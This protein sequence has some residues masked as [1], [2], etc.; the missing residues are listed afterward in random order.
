MSTII[1][2]N[3][4]GFNCEE[5]FEILSATKVKLYA[6]ERQSVTEITER[7]KIRPL[8][9]EEIEKKAKRLV[10][11]AL[12]DEA[13]NFEI[14]V[15]EKYSQSYFEVDF[16]CGSVPRKP[17]PP[18]N[19]ELLQFHLFSFQP[20][21]ELREEK[22][23][24]H[25]LRIKLPYSFWCFIKGYFFDVWT[26]C[27][28]LTN[29]ETGK[30]LRGVKV[31]AMDADFITD[32]RL[33]D[34]ITDL[35]GKFTIYYS[36]KDFKKTFLSPLINI[37]TDISGP[38]ASGPDVYFKL[39]YD[40][41]QFDLETKADRRNN[42]GYCLC[43]KLCV[44]EL[45]PSDNSVPPSFTHIGIAR[46][47]PIQSGINSATGKTM[48]GFAHQGSLNLVGAISQK[49]NNRPMEYMFEYQQVTNPSASPLPG[50]WLPVV[51]NMIERT[52]IGYLY[53][54]SMDIN[55]PI[56][57]EYVYVNGIAPDT[58]A[59]FNGNWIKVPQD[60]NFAAGNDNA[61]LRLNTTK[62]NGGELT[63]LNMAMPTSQIG[64][65]TV[66]AGRPHTKNKYFALRMKVRE[67][68]NNATIA[69][70]GTSKPIAIFNV[71][72]DN[73]NKHGSWAPTSEVGQGIAVSVDIQEIVAGAVG[74]S[75]ITNALHVKYEARN[76]N[77]DSVSLSIT[78]PRKPGQSF[79]FPPI[80]LMPAPETFETTQ[81]VFN[82][83]TQTVQ[84]MLPCAYTVHISATA[85]ITDG[86]SNLP[87]HQDFVSFCKVD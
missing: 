72:Y 53:T 4:L 41:Q 64:S 8:S 39:E 79:D 30:P 9:E 63:Q 27:G 66:N 45:I 50:S 71:S 11:E 32:D 61:I 5:C 6:A 28:R 77:L 13:G 55:N 18:K 58:I 75:K 80:A 14:K 23:A 67:A 19:G 68:G 54:P 3:I 87:A 40:G 60:V 69:I 10:G 82:P 78:G 81:L 7:G 57:K 2:G 65:A 49:L 17:F 46:F 51:P 21:W 33:G 52:R 42:V 31:I 16:E 12:S 47:T 86:E 35:N 22:N 62:I 1:K 24:Y 38:F 73:V 76:E 56:D 37:E 84:D 59:A 29:C 48:D 85:K 20:K 83:P 15:D 70:A 36:S 74:C 44:K 25:D 26:I 43:V 34:D